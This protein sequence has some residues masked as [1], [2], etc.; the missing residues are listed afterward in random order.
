MEINDLTRRPG[1][2]LRGGGP[3]SEVVISS[4]IRLARNLEP[5]MF[6]SRADESQRRE[7]YRSLVDRILESDLGDD[8]LVVDMEDADKLDRQLLVERHLISRQH[9]EGQGCR[10]V[11]VTP[12]ERLALM[13]NEEDH[14]R[15]QCL[16]SG[17]QLDTLWSEINGRRRP[18][19]GPD[20]LCL[21]RALRISD[22]LPDQRR[23]RHSRLGHAAPARLEDH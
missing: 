23:H 19:R 14:L 5:Y 15:I 2:W 13:V 20:Q 3:L 17:L 22:R 21:R 6:L 8:L 16:R 9:S 7:I 1:E 12:D 11:V 4:R 18:H 10:G